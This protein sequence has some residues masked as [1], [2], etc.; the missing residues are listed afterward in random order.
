MIIEYKISYCTKTKNRSMCEVKGT[1]Y[2]IC[3]TLFACAL[4]TV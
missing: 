1:S 2:G 3:R 4:M